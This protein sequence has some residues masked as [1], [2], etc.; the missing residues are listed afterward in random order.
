VAEA[1]RRGS[2]PDAP[3][4]SDLGEVTI[5]HDYLNQRGGAERVVL[6]MSKLQPAAPIFTSLYRRG[7]TFE[8]FRTLDVRTAPLDQLP[9]DRRFRALFPLYPAAFRA[10]GEVD[11]DVVISSSSGWAHRVQTTERAFHVVY[12]HTPPRWLWAEYGGARFGQALLSTVARSARRGD[13]RA[14][15]RTDMYIANSLETKKRIS[16]AYGIDAPVVYPPVEIERFTP[17]PRGDR[18]LVVARLVGHK[19]VDLAVDAATELGIGL[20]VVGTGPELAKLRL[21]A[22]PTVAFHGRLSDDAVT[23]LYQG[24]RALIMPGYEDFGITPVEAQAAGKPVIALAEGGALE[25]VEDGVSGALFKEREVPSVIDAI[26]RC[27]DMEAEPRVLRAL[28]AR[29]SPGEFRR[30]LTAAIV[31]GLEVRSEALAA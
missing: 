6:E 18:L 15:L 7:S 28:A 29:F 10:F 2:L 12:C 9:V 3:P 19:R 22:G 20:D 16:R 24:C 8:E 4:V 11:A 5:V 14:A 1:R 30:S 26:R 23:A 31:A 25:T 17:T 13:R 27:D 21:R